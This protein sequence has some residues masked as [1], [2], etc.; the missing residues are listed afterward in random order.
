MRK[1]INFIESHVSSGSNE[2]VNQNKR[3]VSHQLVSNI[4]FSIDI[5]AKRCRVPI[6]SWILNRNLF[7][8]AS[9]V[10]VC[11]ARLGLDRFS[12]WAQN[13]WAQYTSKAYAFISLL[14]TW[15]RLSC[16]DVLNVRQRSIYI[17]D[18][19]K[20]VCAHCIWSL[21]CVRRIERQIQTN[22]YTEII[23]LKR[24]NVCA[25]CRTRA[26]TNAEIESNRQNK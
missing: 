7:I 9:S 14:H 26:S 24:F 4:E 8:T 19:L 22:N 25:H 21:R 1:Q 15:F 20:S 17:K 23:K 10:R 18:H 5:S 16:A 2:W 12:N 3:I 6:V 11:C 13:I